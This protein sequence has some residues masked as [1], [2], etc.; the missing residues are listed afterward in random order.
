MKRSIQ[1]IK[2]FVEDLRGTT[3]TDLEPV[4]YG[5]WSSA[6]FFRTEG[7]NYVIR[8]SP[9][10]EDFKKDA[11]AANFASGQLPIP[12]ITELGEAWGGYYA[13]S[14]KAE[15]VVLELLNREQ[16]RLTVPS[17][18]S[19]LD[20]LRNADLSGTTG[21]GGWDST[22][23]GF[24]SSWRENLLDIA[25]DRSD[26]R[27]HGWREKLESSAVGTKPFDDLYRRFAS[28]VEFCPEDRCLIHADLLHYNLLVL[29]HRV[30]AVID[31]GCSKYGDFLYELA[32]FTFWAPWHETLAGIDFKKL[33]A[34][35][36]ADIGLD[37]PSFDER[38]RCYELHIALDGIAYC[39]FIE[40]WEMV[41]QIARQAQDLVARAF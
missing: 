6:Y 33:A 3:V 18:M 21:Y 1:T 7:R 2:A 20:A 28:L 27:I 13:I 24:S 17:I 23:Q 29:D 32:W 16:M 34:D 35:H 14:E 41:E 11:F 15:G 26:L 8:F 37:V 19:L 10:D 25:S 9:Y 12:R 36:Y 5:E 30:T 39:A 4:G 31:W 38:V 40:N 22:G